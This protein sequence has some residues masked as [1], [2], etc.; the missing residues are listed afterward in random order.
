MPHWYG[1]LPSLLYSTRTHAHQ[2]WKKCCV[3]L[4]Y[5]KNGRA[6]QRKTPLPVKIRWC[7][8]IYFQVILSL[9]TGLWNRLI[10]CID[11]ESSSRA[12]ALLAT[13]VCGFVGCLK[14]SAQ[15]WAEYFE[16]E[17][18]FE[19][20]NKS[21]IGTWSLRPRQLFGWKTF[22]SFRGGFF[23]SLPVIRYINF[24]FV[25]PRGAHVYKIFALTVL[26]SQ[27][28]GKQRRS[29]FDVIHWLSAGTF[30]CC[31]LQLKKMSFVC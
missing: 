26:K 4:H 2:D 20:V 13:E 11:D 15:D 16:P 27:T 31:M 28:V 23:F 22:W 17:S 19:E 14:A 25:L 1:A 9:F 21:V 8:V 10:M 12:G 5:S 18:Q 24:L 3:T 7:Q 30:F 29:N 6:A